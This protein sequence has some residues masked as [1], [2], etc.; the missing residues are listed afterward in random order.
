MEI[1]QDDKCSKIESL[2][3]RGYSQHA[4][5]YIQER[6]NNEPEENYWYR[7]KLYALLD[8]YQVEEIRKLIHVI[9]SKFPNTVESVI[10]DAFVAGLSFKEIKRRLLTA[11]NLDCKDPFLFYM[12]GK[13]YFY[14]GLFKLALT[15]FQTCLALNQN[16]Y[17]AINFYGDCLSKFGYHDL[18]SNH[19]KCLFKN[20]VAFNKQELLTKTLVSYWVNQKN[21]LAELYFE[22]HER[23]TFFKISDIMLNYFFDHLSFSQKTSQGGLYRQFIAS[24]KSGDFNRKV[25]CTRF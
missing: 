16:F 8:R 4:L 9:K 10:A 7:L 14:Q 13:I 5:P 21:V 18:A 17:L 22:P 23:N 12:I 24:V 3:M 11:R 25:N 19:F 6:I 20:D 1:L 15:N 2:L